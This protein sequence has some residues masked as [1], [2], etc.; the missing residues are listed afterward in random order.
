MAS[1]QGPALLCYNDAQFSEVDFQSI[2]RI[3]DSL[4]KEES[5]GAKTGRFGV[6]FNSVYVRVR[7]HGACV[8][9]GLEGW[10][11]GRETWRCIQLVNQLAQRL[12]TIH[13]PTQP[14][15]HPPTTARHGAPHLRLG[16]PRRALR[17]AGGVPPRGEPG[18]PGQDDRLPPPPPGHRGLPRPVPPPARLWLRRAGAHARGLPRHA[19]PLSLAHARPSRDEPA[20]E[21]GAFM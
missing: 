7:V 14:N 8:Q 4:K 12:C 11:W 1:L 16:Q 20:L 15:P 13:N 19:L 10:G 18:E 9:D 2:Q 3:G 21:A 5:R 6:G 17:P